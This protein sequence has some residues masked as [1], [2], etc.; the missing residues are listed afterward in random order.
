MNVITKFDGLTIA[1]HGLILNSGKKKHRAISLSELDKIYIKAY[2]LK[3]LHELGFILFPFLLIF[4]SAH[5]VTLD[6][7]MFV[8]L[9]SFIPILVKINNYKSYGLM[10]CL[11]DGTVF[12][13]KFSLNEKSKNISI[14]NAV[15]REQLHHNTKI[16]APYKMDSLE[17]CEI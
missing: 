12:R 7:V 15:R 5:Y 8:G 4:L 10:L 3:P 2:K 6:K 1:E 14:I 9:S 17:F 13:K 16:N 11:Q